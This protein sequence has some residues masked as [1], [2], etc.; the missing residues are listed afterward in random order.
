MIRWIRAHADPDERPERGRRHPIQWLRCLTD[1]DVADR[2]ITLM[3]GGY[4]TGVVVAGVVGLMGAPSG[5]IEK[6][7]GGAALVY[8]GG[9][10]LAGIGGLYA[11]AAKL[12]RAEAAAIVTLSALS[13]EH[14][15]LVL[16]GSELDASAW[17]TAIRIGIAP[18]MM[19]PFA[20]LRLQAEMC[21]VE[22]IAR[23]ENRSREM[24]VLR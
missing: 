17:Q 19:L 2:V 15:M 11:L 1:A 12:R 4:M 13:L 16:I 20:V 24:G 22:T 10:V 5:A 18:L 21:R 9:M 14:A 7:S 6:F 8:S 23:I 3:L